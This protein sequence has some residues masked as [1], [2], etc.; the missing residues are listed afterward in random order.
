MRCD[1]VRL[2]RVLL[3]ADEASAEFAE[4]ARHLE[5]CSR[6]RER[7]AELSG[8]D[9]L[10]KE[11][12]DT[13]RDGGEPTPERKN[14]PASV[15]VSVEPLLGEDNPIDCETVSLDFLEPASH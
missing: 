1:D 12:C 7:L 4:T 13:L 10:V 2:E 8:A 9:D 5:S 6:C 14:G 11:A 3:D 15:V